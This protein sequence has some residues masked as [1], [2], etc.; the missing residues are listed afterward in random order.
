MGEVVALGAEEHGRGRAYALSRAP[1]HD[2]TTVVTTAEWG[3]GCRRL[4]QVDGQ[5]RVAALVYLGFQR[6]PDTL[7]TV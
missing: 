5:V 6:T 2:V 4:V 7:A 1:L 3:V